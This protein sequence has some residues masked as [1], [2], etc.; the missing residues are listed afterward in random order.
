M[1]RKLAEA[2]QFTDSMKMFRMARLSL[3]EDIRL[4]QGGL[5]EIE[6]PPFGLALR[7]TPVPEPSGGAEMR[8]L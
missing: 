2:E 3:S 5:F 6:A 7:S 1:H 4:E 8:A